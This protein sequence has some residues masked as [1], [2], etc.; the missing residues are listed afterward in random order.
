MVG[1]YTP[2]L[3][4]VGDEIAVVAP[5]D[6]G[7]PSIWEISKKKGKLY[8]IWKP[9][10]ST[11]STCNPCFNSTGAVG[12]NKIADPSY[13][14]GYRYDDYLYLFYG[15][16]DDSWAMDNIAYLGSYTEA[17]NFVPWAFDEAR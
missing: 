16:K 1:K 12:V 13:H 9:T 6:N 3:V 7:Q 10:V 11:A 15:Y 8:W 17:E 2:Q 4:D 5:D 14:G